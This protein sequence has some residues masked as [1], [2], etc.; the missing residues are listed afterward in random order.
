MTD[1]TTTTDRR[2]LDLRGISA[3][4]G[5]AMSTVVDRLVP[6]G[7][8][9]T[10]IGRRYL[11]D[12]EQVDQ[13]LREHPGDTIEQTLER[14]HGEWVAGGGVIDDRTA[15]RIGEALAPARR[16]RLERERQDAS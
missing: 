4:L 7:L 16:R 6:C 2:W 8:P 13:W 14:L 11:F 5:L 15:Q 3:H 1:T 10:R 9:H 12:P